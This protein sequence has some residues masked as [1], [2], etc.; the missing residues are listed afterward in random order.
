MS[1]HVSRKTTKT[2][3][4]ETKEQKYYKQKIQLLKVPFITS[5]FLV[6]PIPFKNSEPLGDC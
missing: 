1:D 6:P 2:N 3:K 5:S 4:Q